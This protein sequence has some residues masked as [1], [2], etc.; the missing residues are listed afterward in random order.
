MFACFN[1]NYHM[2]N[3]KLN[4][5]YRHMAHKSKKPMS[6]NHI[7]L[8]GNQNGNPQTKKYIKNL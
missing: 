7:Y 2:D 8:F 5:N 3:L 1:E 4:F 6:Y